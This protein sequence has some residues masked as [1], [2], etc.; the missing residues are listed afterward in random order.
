M[1]VPTS[2]LHIDGIKA[3]QR[4]ADSAKNT[5]AKFRTANSC[6]STST[7]YTAV[8]SCSSTDSGHPMVNPG[9]ISYDG[10][11]VPT[12]WCA[13]NDPSY[14]ATQHGIPRLAIKSMVDFLAGLW[15]RP[16]CL[17][18]GALRGALEWPAVPLAEALP[19]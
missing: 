15:A 18:R 5:V 6:M 2:V 8:M 9:C 10:C 13:D 19:A 11:S 16:L 14:S 3:N 1:A 12:I 17:A 4:S 7:P